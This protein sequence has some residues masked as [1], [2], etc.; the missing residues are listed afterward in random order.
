[1]TSLSFKPRNC[2]ILY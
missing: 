2:S 1:M